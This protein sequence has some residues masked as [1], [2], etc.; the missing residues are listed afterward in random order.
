MAF[1]RLEVPAGHPQAP[2]IP[3]PLPLARSWP[4][5]VFLMISLGWAMFQPQLYQV[6]RGGLSYYLAVLPALLLPLARPMLL[7]Q[8]ATTR[9]LPI[10]IFGVVA[11]AW[12]FVRGDMDAAIPLLLLTWGVV[13]ISSDAPRIRFDDFYWVYALAV[14]VGAVA[15]L[16]GGVN[17]WGLVPGTTTLAGQ[18]VWRVSF[19]PNIA[20]TGF[21]SLAF[22]IIFTRDPGK[23]NALHFVLLGVAAYF[24]IFSFVRTAVISLMVYFALAWLF[25]R[26]NTPS[27]L[28][29]AALVT[30]VLSNLIIAYSASIFAAIQNNSVFSRL[31]LRGEAGLSE[32]EIYVQLFRPW[33]WG[34]HIHQF[35]TSPFLM[36]WGSA[37]FNDLK[38]DS[39]VFGY[40]QTGDVSLLTK[41]LAQNGLP[42][43]LVLGFLVARLTVLAKRGDA[44][45]CAC[46]PVVILAMMHWGV[47]F[48]PTNATFAIF[49]LFL[50]HG[51]SGFGPYLPRLG[52]RREPRVAGTRTVR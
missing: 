20:I 35:L 33:L 19:F 4:V 6:E 38:T 16:G 24:I 39:L 51:S 49:M 7:I 50:I 40:E 36:G 32:Y 41:L 9:A 27:F 1:V 2:S 29:W 26:K 17:E 37:S 12:H 18:S 52:P 31:F 47:I 5:L 48:H 3:G 23:K 15:W 34:Q 8:A 14:V 22:I 44:W 30:A 10:V 45:G 42:A 21:L 25:R 13:W 11:A 46:F 43:L 28:F